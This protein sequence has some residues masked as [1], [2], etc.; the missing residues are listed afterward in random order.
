MGLLVNAIAAPFKFANAVRQ[1]IDV[2]K[3]RRLTLTDG[4][5]W[6]R[7]FGRESASGKIV[8]MESALQLATVWAC[9]RLTAQAVSCLPL[10]VYEKGDNDSRTKVDDDLAEIISETP[11]SDQTA[12][13]FWE[14]NV[15]W[16][17]ADGNAYS[18]RV[19]VGKDRLVALQPIA[20][21][22]CRPYR[23]DDGT[24]VFRVTDRGKP[25]ELPRD[26]VLHLKG[27]GQAFTNAD[28]GMSPI[29]AG[30]Q[31][32][33]AAMAADEMAG[34]M[35]ANGLSVAGILSAKQTLKDRQRAEIQ[36]MMKEFVGSSR[37]GKMMVLEGG[38]EYESAQLNPDDAQMLET[39]RF[40]VEEL[41]RWF[42]MPPIIIGHAGQGQTMWGSGVEQIMIS[43]LTLGIDPLCDR[44]EA[45]IKKQLIR[46]AG[47]KRRYAEFNREALLQMDSQAKASFLSQMVQNGLMDRNEGRRKLNLPNKPGADQL[48]AQTNLA[49]LDKLGQDTGGSAQARNALMSWLGIKENTNDRS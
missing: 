8:T 34:R 39:R 26:K 14:G 12:L 29:G 44:I 28:C 25:E 43:W 40:S 19:T 23:K 15:A 20:S 4:L 5:G 45:R 42:G 38:L 46:P 13:E 18:E 33:G 35:F 22:R 11:N 1:E 27:F 16:L 9:I 49:P 6:S 32:M 2:A 3:E 41:C 10:A 30:V 36:A 37:A 7:F 48:T 17:L 47:N 21:S 31:S 24:L